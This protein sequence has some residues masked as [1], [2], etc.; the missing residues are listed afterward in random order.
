[1]TLFEIVV[2]V[3]FLFFKMM[4]IKYWMIFLN[5]FLIYL[6]LIS[7][8]LIVSRDIYDFLFFLLVWLMKIIFGLLL[9]FTLLMDFFYGEFIVCLLIY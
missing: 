5:N 2:F 4:W 8:I 3:L 1:M 6:V 7:F 9:L